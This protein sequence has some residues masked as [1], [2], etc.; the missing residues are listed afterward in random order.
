MSIKFTVRVPAGSHYAQYTVDVPLEAMGATSDGSDPAQPQDE[1]TRFI[2]KTVAAIHRET[3]ALPGSEATTQVPT[4]RSA[5]GSRR[6]EKEKQI[7]ESDGGEILTPRAN[8]SAISAPKGRKRAFDSERAVTLDPT[9]TWD[10]LMISPSPGCFDSNS[11]EICLRVRSTG[12]E[13][14]H[15]IDKR[16]R[17]HPAL[18]TELQHMADKK[19]L[20]LHRLRLLFD[21]VPVKARDTACGVGASVSSSRFD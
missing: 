18:Q 7:A 1:V 17:L 19:G 6:G 16:R 11:I 5:D 14:R 15:Y 3:T 10:S 4:P 20:P 13:T 21:G 9:D 12:Y 8:S 2:S